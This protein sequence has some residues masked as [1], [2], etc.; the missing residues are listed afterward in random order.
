LI[1]ER[2]NVLGFDRSE[3]RGAQLWVPPEPTS[4]SAFAL[5]N[6]RV[7]N[8]KE[9]DQV[10]AAIDTAVD[11]K[12]SLADDPEIAGMLGAMSPLSAVTAVS[13]ADHAAACYPAAVAP[14]GDGPGLHN[15][16]AVGYG[17]AGE[18]SQRRTLIVTTFPDDTAATAGLAAYEAGWLQGFANAGGAG[19]SIDTFGRLN[20]VTQSANRLV[21]EI[22][23]GR[24][25]GWVRS[26]VRYAI[27]VCEAALAMAPPA[28]PDPTGGQ[29]TLTTMQRLVAALPEVGT[30]GDFRAVDFEGISEKTGGAPGDMGSQ[31][32]AD[33]WKQRTPRPPFSVIPDDEAR[34]STWAQTLGIPLTNLIAVGEARTARDHSPVAVIL[35]AWDRDTLT[36]TLSAMG[37]QWIDIGGVRHFALPAGA[38]PTSTLTE[39]AGDAWINIAQLGDRLWVSADQREM[40]LAVDSATGASVPN[41]AARLL[42]AAA[43]ETVPGSTALEV[44]GAD[45][46][47]AECG[48]GL[49]GIK[50]IVVAWTAIADSG[51][52]KIV[53]LSDG[54]VPASELAAELDTRLEG[55]NL[56]R[57]RADGAGPGTPVAVESVPLFE[58]F[59]HLDTVTADT[60]T[61]RAVVA[62]IQVVGAGSVRGVAFFEGTSGG[63][64]LGALLSA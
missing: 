31:E 41:V 25:D 26:G 38:K 1:I 5:L 33:W 60:T 19:G 51:Q 32:R 14:A 23:E 18:P 27:P 17:R 57:S 3:Y 43:I 54:S 6:G 61:G 28:T 50:A 56:D 35:G 58:I 20:Y 2:L 12:G 4:G 63:C 42:L 44:A 45:F 36:T 37:Y 48:L 47:S 13:L 29:A 59:Y 7:I 24:D 22:V 53:Y 10:R 34:F 55:L 39:I 46:R 8:A 52:A 21:V 30:A 9:G 62:R 40:R 11:G 15:Y 16:V 49:P 64:Q